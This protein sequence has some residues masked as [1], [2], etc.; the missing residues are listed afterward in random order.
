MGLCW[1]YITGI[2]TVHQKHKW[3]MWGRNQLIEQA[4]QWEGDSVSSWDLLMTASWTAINEILTMLVLKLLS[5]EGTIIYC[6]RWT[7]VNGWNP[8]TSCCP[9]AWP[10]IVVSASNLM[11]ITQNLHCS[12][13]LCQ[14]HTF[15]STALLLLRLRSL[16]VGADNAPTRLDISSLYI[17]SRGLH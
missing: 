15:I 14:S 11:I 5:R 3:I 16:L 1:D 8:S 13:E 4:W 10:C 2:T 17:C 6:V 9:A 7:I 12:A